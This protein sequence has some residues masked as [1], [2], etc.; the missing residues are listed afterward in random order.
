[1][2]AD[3]GLFFYKD[4]SE[5][6]TIGSILLPSYSISPCSQADVNKKFAF[7]AEHENMKTYYFAADNQ[8]AMGQWVDALRMA[9]LVQR[10]PG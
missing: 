3:F 6:S 10:A 9:A 5:Q 2:L 8:N 7:K 4:D 1:M